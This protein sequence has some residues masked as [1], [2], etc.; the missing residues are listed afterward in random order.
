MQLTEDNIRYSVTVE[1]G[2]VAFYHCKAA[3]YFEE[4]RDKKHVNLTC[5][6]D[7]T[8]EEPAVWDECVP[9]EHK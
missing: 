2:E 1:F 6:N 3:T 7:G 8:F 9:S 4:D 5:L